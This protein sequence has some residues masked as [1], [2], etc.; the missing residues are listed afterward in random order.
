MDVAATGFYCNVST[1][2]APLRITVLPIAIVKHL[3]RVSESHE[4]LFE[5]AMLDSRIVSVERVD[6]LAELP[7]ITTPG[8]GLLVR[9][10]AR[11]K[12]P[13]HSF[14]HGGVMDFGRLHTHRLFRTHGVRAAQDL[15]DPDLG[16]PEVLRM[17]N[18]AHNNPTSRRRCY[19]HEGGDLVSIIY[20]ETGPINDRRWVCSRRIRGLHNRPC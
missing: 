5:I 8:S 13:S 1:D 17:R 7:L 16:F 4:R 20:I 2:F 15:T 9:V 14:E 12:S 19:E 6:T 18:E 10:R 3:A 11:Q